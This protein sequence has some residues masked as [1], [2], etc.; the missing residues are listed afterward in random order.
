[1]S[2]GSKNNGINVTYIVNIIFTPQGLFYFLY[3]P[4]KKNVDICLALRA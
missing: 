2:L 4:L 1:M 3:L